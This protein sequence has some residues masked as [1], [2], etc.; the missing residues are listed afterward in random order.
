MNGAANIFKV[1]ELRRRIFMSLVLL[2]VYRIGCYIPVPGIDREALA[3]F[4]QQ[5]GGIIGLFNLFAGGALKRLSI[6]ALGI[7]PYISTAIIMELLTVV[8]PELGQ[9]KKKANTAGER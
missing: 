6:F 5:A 2:A 3:Y 1:P 8:I 9:L 4:F 7:M